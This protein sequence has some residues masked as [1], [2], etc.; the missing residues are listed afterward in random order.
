MSSEEMGRP[1]K[2]R[3]MWVKAGIVGFGEG[4]C[5]GRERKPPV[6]CARRLRSSPE[7]GM[8][9]EETT[10]AL[11]GADV[12]RFLKKGILDNNFDG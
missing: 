2:A 7:R 1:S 8:R 4:G 5:V 9:G 10:E 11:W 3:W 12:E 6:Y